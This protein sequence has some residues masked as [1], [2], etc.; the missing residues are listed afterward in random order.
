MVT[1][2]DSLDYEWSPD[3]HGLV[4]SRQGRLY[5]IAKEGGEPLLLPPTGD[6]PYSLRFSRDGQSIFY[7]V[8][9]GPRE[10][11]D[12]WKLSLDDGK[13]SRLTRLEGRRGSIGNLATDGRY[14]YFPWQED[15]GD[16]W[17]MNVVH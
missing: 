11:H 8:I 5:R 13:V 3:G 17:V 6:E 10:K 2:K 12:F 14:L 7:S 4:V 16:I 9:T 15:D 1:T